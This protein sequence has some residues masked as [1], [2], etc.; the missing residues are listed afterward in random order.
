MDRREF[1]AGIASATA[2]YSLPVAAQ[3]A[4]PTKPVRIVVAFPPGQATDLTARLS[5][6][7]LT[8]LWGQSVVVENR[9]GGA[10]IPGVMA[11]RDAPADGYTLGVVSSGTMATNVSLM[12]NL[13]YDPLKDFALV[14]G[15]VI[16]PMV[17]VVQPNSAIKTLDDLVQHAKANPGQL[18]WAYTGVG[19]AQHITGE[20]FKRRAGIQV[21]DVMYKGSAPAAQDFLGERVPLLWDTF[22]AVRQH[23]VSG[24][25]RPVAVTTLQRLPQL[26]DVPSIA[27]SGYPGFE[28]VGWVGIVAPVAT[29]EVIVQKL[30]ADSRT[31]LQDAALRERLHSMGLVVDPRGLKEWREYVRHEI[32]KN[33]DIV[34]RAGS[35]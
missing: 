29:P 1:L 30:A 6:D 19:A 4:Y 33:K 18:S 24:R 26:P 34:E 10:G 12:K 20:M 3:G 28:N 27:E 13:P 16:A 2:A 31:V 25:M 32:E 14:G 11:V 23:I 17:L 8:K 7:A 21:L 35:S 22:A 5:A 15:L 9:P